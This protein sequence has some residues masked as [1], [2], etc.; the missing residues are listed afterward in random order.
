MN[1][2]MASMDALQNWFFWTWKI[3]VSTKLGVVGS[4]LWSYQLGLQGGWMPKDPRT[5]SGRCDA[6]GGAPN[7]P[8]DGTY[9][10]WMT[11]GAGA[12]TIAATY[13]WP[14][15]SINGADA[16]VTLLHSYTSTG[17]VSTLP[18]PTLTAKA[19]KSV[20]AGERLVRCAG[21]RRGSDAD[22]R[23]HVPEC[24]GRQWCGCSCRLWGRCC[25]CCGAGSRHLLP[26]LLLLPGRLL[27]LLLSMWQM[28][29]LLDVV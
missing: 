14:P 12:G 26:V 21:Y 4:P 11:G 6:I 13:A 18:P 29:Q 17:P 1:F 27:L 24:V 28:R 15:A 8:F 2:A 3:G 10:S 22:C 23:V 9:Q 5:A 7:V 19:T 20:D 16:A 25:C